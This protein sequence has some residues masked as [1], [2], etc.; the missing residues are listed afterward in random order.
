MLRVASGHSIFHLGFCS[1]PRVAPYRPTIDEFVL[2]NYIYGTNEERP[3]SNVVTQCLFSVFVCVCFFLSFR[4]PLRQDI[5]LL[6]DCHSSKND[7]Q[8]CHCLTCSKEEAINYLD[9]TISLKVQVDLFRSQWTK[10]NC[11]FPRVI[12]LYAVIQ[13]ASSKQQFNVTGNS[14]INLGF[15]HRTLSNDGYRRS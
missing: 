1:C 6:V 11:S 10:W 12:N 9:T 5:V 8:N 15:L 3:E 2:C 4:S 14:N 13:I 7:S